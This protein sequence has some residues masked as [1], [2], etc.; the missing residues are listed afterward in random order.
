[1]HEVQIRRGDAALTESCGKYLFDGFEKKIYI[2]FKK[3]YNI[4]FVLRYKSLFKSRL[5]T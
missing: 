5:F 1:M 4:L 3:L 2:T